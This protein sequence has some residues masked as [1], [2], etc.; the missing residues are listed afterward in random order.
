MGPTEA[1][2][3]LGLGA[4]S[5]FAIVTLGSRESRHSSTPLLL[6]AGGVWLLVWA[7]V[8]FWLSRP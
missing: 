2:L 1:S 5:A 7:G 4:A 8:L 6:V 3:V